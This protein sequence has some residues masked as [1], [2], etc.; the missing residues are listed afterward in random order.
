MKGMRFNG[1]HLAALDIVEGYIRLGLANL[2]GNPG[3]H[4]VFEGHGKTQSDELE[5]FCLPGSFTAEEFESLL[6][7]AGLTTRHSAAA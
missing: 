7:D 6:V 4:T 3:H 2:L 5:A 1:S